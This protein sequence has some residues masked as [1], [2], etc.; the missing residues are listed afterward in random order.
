M[1]TLII[2]TRHLLQPPKGAGVVLPPPH[3]QYPYPGPSGYEIPS[4]PIGYGAPVPVA[5]G[6][7]MPVPY[8]QGPRNAGAFYK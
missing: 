7:A 3:G 5:A 2:H 8:L 4:V 6:Y 1:A